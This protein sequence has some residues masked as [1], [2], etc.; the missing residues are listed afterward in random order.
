MDASL[1]QQSLRHAENLRAQGQLAAAEDL[2]RRLVQEFAGF[3][4]GWNFLGV[5]HADAGRPMQAADAFERACLLAPHDATYPANLGELL[6]RNGLAERAVDFCRRA[7]AVDAGHASA[8]LNLGYALLDTDRIDEAAEHLQWLVQREPGLASAWFGLGRAHMA[9]S[10][11]AQALDCLT[12]CA[13]LNPN[14]PEVA[15]ALAHAQRCLGHTA[16]AQ[17]Q[18]QRVAALLPGHPA[19]LALQADLLLEQGRPDAAE[20]AIRATLRAGQPAAAGVLYR[21]ALCRLAQGDYLE[22]FWLFESRLH[23]TRND[24]SNPIARPVLPMPLWQGEPLQGKRLLVLTEQGYGDHIQFCRFV[25]QLAALGAQVTLAVGPPL[26]QLMLGLP[27][28]ARVVTRIEEARESGCDY[29]TF[30]ASLPHRLRVNAQHVGIDGPYLHADDARRT[31]WRQRLTHLGPGRRVGLVWGG[32]PENEYERRRTVP[33]QALAALRSALPEVR[34]VSLQMGPRA[35]DAAS[36]ALP[37]EV[38]SPDELGSFADTAALLCELDALVSVDTAFAHL[39]GALGRPL[40]LMLP[41]GCDW[42]WGQHGDRTA[43]YASARLHRQTAAGRWD[44]VVT[45]VAAA[46]RM[47][48]A[49]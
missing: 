14:D 33:L 43:W 31:A 34:W 25:P 22:G 1:L 44:D 4:A 13:T 12:R 32:R 38:L 26:A 28:C 47:A 2:C 39:A 40:Q 16:Q 24:I 42:R 49:P 30:V 15:L 23:L 3:A 11:F 8:R 35:G 6:R 46:L 48:P 10:R 5:L 18:A 20:A 9:R 21:L 19:V 27:G 41:V 17:D 29:W 36:G 45:R 37:M 7:L